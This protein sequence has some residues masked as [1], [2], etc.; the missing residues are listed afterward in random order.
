MALPE[1]V[2]EQLGREP[3]KTP[4]WAFGMVLFSGGAFFIV[5]IIYFGLTLG[6]EPYLN[7]QIQATQDQITQLGQSISPTDQANLLNFYS[8][9]SNLRTLLRNHALSSQLFTWLEQN[10]EANVYLTTFNFTNGDQIAFS[11]NAKTEADVNQQIA[12]FETS[13]LVQKVSVTTVAA[14]QQGTG[15]TFGV[16]LVLDPSIFGSSFNAGAPGATG[17]ATTTVNTVPTVP[18]TATTTAA[19]TTKQ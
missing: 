9:V 2:I 1:K 6:Y 11:A 17:A 13:P 19:T 4:G 18:T 14:A 16:T 3:V 7:N 10:T 5:L 12:I 15:F 8:Q